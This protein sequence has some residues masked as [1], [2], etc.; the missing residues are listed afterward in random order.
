MREKNDLIHLYGPV[1]SR[2]LGFS[3]GLD[4]I[5]FKTCSLDCIYCQLG[6][7]TKKTVQR[8]H[9]FTPSVILHQI[10]KALDSGK[11]IDYITFSGSGEPTLNSIIG[12]LIKDIKKMTSIPVAVLT[13]STLISRKNVRKELIDADLVVPSLDA[14]A[15]EV[16]I[17]INRPHP[18]LKL[19][20][21][22]EGLI[23]FRQESKGS[24]WLEIML[25]KGINDSPR[26]IQKLIK[27]IYRMKPDKVQLNTVVRPPAEEFAQALSL[28]EME[29]IKKV[30][31][32]PCEI[33]A[34]FR[35]KEQIPSSQNLEEAVFLMIQRRPVTIAD[36]SVTLGKHQNEVV[37]YTHFLSKKGKIKTVF[38]KGLTYYEPT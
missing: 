25:V 37:K 4:I 28:K 14:A 12:R 1:P 31:N 35:Q 19:K 34:D 6:R 23:S 22:I 30:L 24:L 15:S 20:E 2:R 36:I 32:S 7:T 26:H 27:A 10:Q 21:I 16:F 3:L 5:P 11:K 33:I 38:H 17:T 18:S 9:Y 8:R 13:N 29:R